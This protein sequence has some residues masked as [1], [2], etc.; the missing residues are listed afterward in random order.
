MTV[1]YRDLEHGSKV[2]FMKGAPE[3]VLDACTY[4][5]QGEVLTD[6]AKVDILTLMDRFASQGLVNLFLFFS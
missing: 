4:D 5:P 6:S 2:A 1:V 3:R